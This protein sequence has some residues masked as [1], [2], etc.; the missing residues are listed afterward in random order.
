MKLKV[1]SFI[2]STD[3]C[4]F[5]IKYKGADQLVG[6]HKKIEPDTFGKIVALF[7]IKAK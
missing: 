5:Y 2:K 3:T 7:K 4:G 1:K 6:V